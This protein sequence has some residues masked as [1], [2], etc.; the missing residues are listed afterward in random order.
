MIFIK[1]IFFFPKSSKGF[2]GRFQRHSG[3]RTI[4]RLD[5]L[6]TKGENRRERIKEATFRVGTRENER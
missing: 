3:E 1:T 5:S 6:K 4:Q 2:R